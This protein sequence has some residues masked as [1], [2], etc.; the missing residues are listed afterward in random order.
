MQHC[1]RGGVGRDVVAALVSSAG[2]EDQAFGTN[3]STIYCF[4]GSGIAFTPTRARSLVRPFVIPSGVEESL[5]TSEDS[6][7][8]GGSGIVLSPTRARYSSACRRSGPARSIILSRLSIDE[9]SSSCSVKNHC[10]KLIVM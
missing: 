9:T 7:C 2:L 1:C 6:Y 5:A 10:R 8:F 3:A 4:G